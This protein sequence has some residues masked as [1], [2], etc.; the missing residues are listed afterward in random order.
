[1]TNIIK[2][3]NQNNEQA[4]QEILKWEA[5]HA[6]W[7]SNSTRHRFFMYFTGST[8]WSKHKH[9]TMLSCAVAVNVHVGR[10]WRGLVGKLKSTRPGL[11]SATGWG[12]FVPY[13]PEFLSTIL[14]KRI[15]MC[16]V[17][18]LKLSSPVLLLSFSATSCLLTDTTGLSTAVGRMCVTSLTTMMVMSTKTTISSPSWMYAPPLTL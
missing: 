1:M 10:P 18:M 16:P 4:W 17:Y 7:V 8:C 15:S 14:W 12:E 3:H 9:L 6:R 2:I 5:M 13:L 11:A